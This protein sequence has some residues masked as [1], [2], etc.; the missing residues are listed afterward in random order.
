MDAYG[1]DAGEDM[2]VHRH[3]KCVFFRVEADSHGI[4]REK[5]IPSVFSLKSDIGID[6]REAFLQWVIRKS[7]EAGSYTPEP[8]ER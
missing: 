6:K 7:A 1:Y 8:N 5:D 3:L 4:Y 2:I